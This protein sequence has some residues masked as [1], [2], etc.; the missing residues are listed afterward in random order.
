MNSIHQLKLKKE[1]NKK[2]SMVTCY[3]YWSS[4][5]LAETDIDCL[6]VGDS[7]AMV[8]HGYPTTV[9][10]T[11]D[12]IATHTQAVKRGNP[13]CPIVADLPFLAHRKG[14]KV[15]MSSV[16]TLM[17]AG[18]DAIKIETF[19]GQES[20]VR[21]LTESGIPIVGHVGLT[22][23]YVHQFGGYKVQGKTQEDFEQIKKHSIDLEKAG[24]HALVMECVPSVLAQ[25][26]TGVLKI[27]T[28]GIGAG[29]H[30][31]GQV[32][33]LQDLLGLSKN[34]KPK[35]VRN[36]GQGESFL[37]K[38][39]QDFDESVKSATFPSENETFQ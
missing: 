6:L 11:V 5:I 34:F 2:I 36:F 26:I 12:M 17:K 28:I 39:I 35:F 20:T 33:V 38:A 18:A 31:D 10:A 14:K 4:Q 7:V 30:C 37:Q 3:D 23:Q 9:H 32:L 13:S 8:V 25:E 22:P 19:P 15:L 21:Y 16:D 24:C 29:I 27:P 1:A